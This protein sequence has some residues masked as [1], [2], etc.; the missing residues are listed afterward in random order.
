[1][2]F[3]FDITK[4]C[5]CISGD[6]P[7]IIEDTGIFASE[8]ILAADKACSD[9]LTKNRDL[10]SRGGKITAHLHQLEYA[11]EIGLGKLDYKLVK[12]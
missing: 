6:D 8:D 4:E 7:R 5:D 9:M 2:N 12:V 1:M 11:R 3:A 10:F